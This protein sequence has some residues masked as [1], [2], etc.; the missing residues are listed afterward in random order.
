MAALLEPAPA[1]SEEAQS[2][3]AP[4]LEARRGAAPEA[5]PT[6]GL[7]VPAS[8]ARARGRG[9]PAPAAPAGAS[10]PLEAHM[11][12]LRREYQRRGFALARA[13]RRQGAF[14][15]SP[16][17]GLPRPTANCT[18]VRVGNWLLTPPPPRR[19]PFRRGCWKRLPVG[20]AVAH[21]P[22]GGFFLWA[23]LPDDC[24]V[25]ATALASNFAGVRGVSFLPGPRCR[26]PPT[27]AAAAAAAGSESEDLA[28]LD[29]WCRLC[30]AWLREEALVEG[31]RRLALACADAGASPVHVGEQA[32]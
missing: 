11:A 23:R 10:S 1:P 4:S 24:P 2:V 13:L 26:A 8:E 16:A 32:K 18:W 9:S 29:R 20:F 19:R 6:P 21:E 28:E 31:T 27:A 15:Y 5:S 17:F 3:E 7:A 22:T 30:F 12:V 25:G 14:G